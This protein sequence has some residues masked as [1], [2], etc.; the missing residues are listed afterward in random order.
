LSRR[1]PARSFSLARR[2]VAAVL[3]G[4]VVLLGVSAC[5]TRGGVGASSSAG[6]VVATLPAPPDGAA[7]SSPRRCA[8]AIFAA[9]PQ[10]HETG[11]PAGGASPSAWRLADAAAP[12]EWS[13]RVPE[14][15]PRPTIPV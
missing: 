3:V 2:L 8:F 9:L 10:R 6:A 15:P 4:V 11:E 7:K 13:G 14:R 5:L 12:E 1:S